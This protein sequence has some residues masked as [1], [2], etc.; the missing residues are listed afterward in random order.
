ALVARLKSLRRHSFWRANGIDRLIGK[1]QRERA[2]LAA[3]KA[4]GVKRFQLF[5]L[6]VVLQL[7]ADIDE[8]W[9]CCI[10]R[11]EHFGNPRAE[12]RRR[13]GLRRHIAGVPMVLM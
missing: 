9:N 10:A 13:H 11:A 12:V 1:W 5:F 7:L 4:G 6:A 2:K 3:E 8:C